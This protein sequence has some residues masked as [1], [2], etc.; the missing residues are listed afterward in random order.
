MLKLQDVIM[1][2]NNSYIHCAQK[3]PN[4]LW[5]MQV[6]RL[7]PRNPHSVRPEVRLRNLNF[8]KHAQVINAHF[9]MEEG[10]CRGVNRPAQIYQDTRKIKTLRSTCAK[11]TLVYS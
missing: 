1:P 10:R 7:Q 2:P 6:L 4:N 9:E 8:N 3:V 5:L 11:Y